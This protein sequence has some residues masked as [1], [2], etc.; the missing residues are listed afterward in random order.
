MP[1]PL[2][3]P[4]STP[5]A[6]PPAPTTIFPASQKQ[7]FVLTPDMDFAEQH[8]RDEHTDALYRF[9]EF[10][11]F[12]LMWHAQDYDAG[13]VGRCT[14]CMPADDRI[15]RAYQQTPQER[16]PGCFGTTYE[17]GFRAQV[18]RPSLWTDRRP[19]TIESARGTF[20]TDTVTIETTGDFTLRHRDYVLRTDGLRYS[21]EEM[22]E[23]VVR[24]GFDSPTAIQSVGGLIASA[25]MEDRASVVHLIPPTTA[26]LRT[27]LS[28]A[29]DRLTPFDFS[30][31]EVTDRGP[32]IVST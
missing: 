29:N 11:M 14:V 31:Y 4:P 2:P 15:S 8:I 12:V 16:C 24:S 1:I 22:T 10:A 6:P 20:L 7:G 13:L 30:A 18:I 32:L 3:F 25:R 5:T 26:E 19:D 23:Q 28:R 17:G 27:I 9:G 21:T